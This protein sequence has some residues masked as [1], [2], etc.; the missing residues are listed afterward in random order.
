MNYA[1]ISEVT[2]QDHVPTGDKDSAFDDAVTEDGASGK[3]GNSEGDKDTHVDACY[4][5][6]ESGL[7]PSGTAE[8]V[9]PDQATSNL[10]DVS[11]F[12]VAEKGETLEIAPESVQPEGDTNVIIIRI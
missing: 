11:S 9:Q 12:A 4:A 1:K 6:S 8:E 5:T 3:G 7:Q 10:T 2:A